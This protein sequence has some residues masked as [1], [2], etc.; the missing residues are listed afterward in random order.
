MEVS[1]EMTGEECCD[2]EEVGGG[3]LSS[4]CG[5]YDCEDVGDECVFWGVVWCH[6]CEVSLT[7]H[8]YEDV[9][10]GSQL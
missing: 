8:D 3:V 5:S 4:C 6:D 10:D 9:V 2:C 1:R 7:G